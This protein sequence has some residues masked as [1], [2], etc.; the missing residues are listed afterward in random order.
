MRISYWSSD[1]CSSDLRGAVRAADGAES[2]TSDRSACGDRSRRL[3]PS[4]VEDNL[5]PVIASRRRSNPGLAP[6]SRARTPW[7][8]DRTSVVK[9]RS[10]SVSGGLG[11]R[12]ICKKKQKSYKQK[13]NQL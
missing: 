10:V 9:E 2:A 12:R 1:V 13:Y 4:L 6:R 11:G 8:A 3:S 7:V 5:S